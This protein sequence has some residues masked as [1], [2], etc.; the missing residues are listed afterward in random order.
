MGFGGFF[1]RPNGK[2][3]SQQQI[4]HDSVLFAMVSI[5]SSSRPSRDVCHLLFVQ[6]NKILL[7]FLPLACLFFSLAISVWSSITTKSSSASATITRKN[8]S[9]AN[10]EPRKDTH[11]E[12]VNTASR[13]TAA[14]RLEQ[15]LLLQEPLDSNCSIRFRQKQK[16]HSNTTEN[17]NLCHLIPYGMNFGDELGPVVV[18]QILRRYF[19]CSNVDEIPIRN[20]DSK[21]GHNEITCLFSLGSILHYARSGDHVWGTGVNPYWHRNQHRGW[22]VYSTRGPMTR[23]FLQKHNHSID[24]MQTNYGDPGFLTPYMFP[25]FQSNAPSKQ[26]Q[27]QQN[28]ICMVPHFHDLKHANQKLKKNLPNVTIVSP[29][30]HWRPVVTALRQCDFVASSSLHGIILA[31]SMGIPTLWY[32]P[33]STATRKTEGSFKYQDYFQSIQRD[34]HGPARDWKMILDTKQYQ[35]PIDSARRE[36]LARQF[37]RS[38]PI[39]LFERVDRRSQRDPTPEY[40]A[41][42]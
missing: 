30:N 25:E 29:C 37:L 42:S 26:Q 3:R 34:I 2:S 11:V 21:E 12:F 31:D 38:F 16:Q 4:D 17:M 35:A 22:T 24:G 27:L 13:L 7:C 20:L 33:R 15:A 19:Y 9:Q 1:H 23:Q 41:S 40:Q 18:L 36:D 10:T 6:Y 32:Q 14:A 5:A 28:K 39:Y 8:P